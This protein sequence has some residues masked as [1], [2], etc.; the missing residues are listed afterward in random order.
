LSTYCP[1]PWQHLATH[2]HGGITLCCISDHTD[3]LNRARNYKDGYAEF[4]DL[5]KKDINEHMNSD[6][7]K[8]VRLQM[9][10]NKKPQACMRCY[11]EEDKGI[12]SKRQHETEVFK[13]YSSDYA[14]ELTKEDGSID[15]DLRFVELRLGNVCNVRCRTCNPAS[16]SKWLEDYKDI[17]E[18]A[19]FI[20]KGY[21]G[22]NFPEDFKWAEDDNFY[23]DLYESAPNLELLYINGGEPTLIKQHW[24]YL[25]K[26]VDSGRSKNITLWYNINCTMLPPIAL[27]LWPEF[28]EARICLSID[29]LE[30][31]NA[32]IRTGTDWNAVLRTIDTLKQNENKLVLRITQT[33]S[34]Y[35]YATLPEF[36]EW[37]NQ[38]GI[39]VDMNFVYDPDYLSPA[40]IPV[41]ARELIHT[42]FRKALGNDHKLGTLLSMYNND[43]WLELKWEQFCR[44]NDLMDK[45][46]NSNWRETFSELVSK[47]EESGHTTVY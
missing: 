41:K 45:N 38:I 2:P 44:Y 23:D 36:F 10:N 17:V 46:D 37:A 3:G 21:L 40:V 11:E 4:L 26:L 32:F 8:E 9:L 35:N 29:D 13:N 43:E 1:L 20:N 31:R 22:L 25:K 39:E 19:D 27:E 33:V 5:N 28:K 34:A 14:S 15:M 30:E 24:T 12:K 6:Y 42:R 7:Y 18:K 16:S 47:V